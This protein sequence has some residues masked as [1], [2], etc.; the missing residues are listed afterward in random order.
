MVQFT[1]LP[2]TTEGLALTNVRSAELRV[3][4]N[5]DDR[6]LSIPPK[7]PGAFTFEFPVQ[8]W[9][10]KQVILTVRATGPKGK[11]SEW[12]NSVPLA[13]G[14]P[15]P[16][17]TKLKIENTAR[18][19]RLAWQSAASSFR[20]FRGAA[21]ARP[22]RLAESN[23][24]EYLDTTA[25]NGTR[26]LYFVQVLDGELRQSEVSSTVEVTPRDEFP[27]AVPRGLSAVAGVSSV[28]LAWERN[29]EDD[30]SGYN[31][32]RS[33]GDSSYE[34]IASLID[35]PTFSD[36]TV[37]SGVRYRYVLASVDRAGNE[38]ERSAVVDVVAQ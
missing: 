23:Q 12:S 32:Y 7:E 25:E 20:I 28:E 8:D 38:S 4:T 1:V 10:G 22:T 2:L 17:P 16:T 11:V 6:V 19:V 15:L 33:S 30:F 24:A 31:V 26:Y 14:S 18:G 37:Q 27:P 13:V 36:R 35:T 34:K 29:T 3:Q 5:G 21:D 9:I